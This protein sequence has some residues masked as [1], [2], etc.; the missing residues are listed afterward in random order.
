MG[1]QWIVS[2]CIVVVQLDEDP[3]SK[4]ISL[5]G[6]CFSVKKRGENVG[7]PLLFIF[8]IYLLYISSLMP[9]NA[10]SMNGEPVDCDGSNDYRFADHFWVN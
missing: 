1:E 9:P 2:W 4:K 6:N 7:C 8:S 3:A 5:Q 10:T